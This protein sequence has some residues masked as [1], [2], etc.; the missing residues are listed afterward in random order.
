MKR[1]GGWLVWLSFVV[2]FATLLWSFRSWT[3]NE[4]LLSLPSHDHQEISVESH[5]V[6]KKSEQT[7]YS[8]ELAA[9]AHRAEPDRKAAL[10]K[11][12]ALRR[13]SEG[14]PSLA[15]QGDSHRV[16]AA[17]LEVE[18]LARKRTPI[19]NGVAGLGKLARSHGIESSKK[20]LA[21]IMSFRHYKQNNNEINNIANG[22]ESHS[23][24]SHRFKSSIDK[25]VD[26]KRARK[27]SIKKAK[28]AAA[29]R[30]EAGRLSKNEM[31][32][33]ISRQVEHSISKALEQTFIPIQGILRKDETKLDV[34]TKPGIHAAAIN[35]AADDA[36]GHLRQSLMRKL[37]SEVG[38][39]LL[40]RE[41]ALEHRSSAYLDKVH[42]KT[43]AT[44]T[45]I[46]DPDRIR[47]H[48]HVVVPSSAHETV[49]VVAT[50]KDWDRKVDALLRSS[51]KIIRTQ[52]AQYV[53][54]P[55]AFD[56]AIQA[57]QGELERQLK[58]VKLSSAHMSGASSSVASKTRSP[59]K[60]AANSGIHKAVPS[61]RPMSPQ[62]K[63]AFKKALDSY[64]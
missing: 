36:A 33:T 11:L 34:L 37:H 59:V 35:H 58:S 48:S 18:N 28:A 38:H 64:L 14:G 30:L 17:V 51:R 60:L 24:I 42:K 46:V 27:E 31:K 50:G 12:D 16:P 29:L 15:K 3:N 40:S 55:L 20:M 32:K 22:F 4:V 21:E 45:G 2:C 19:S 62:Q 53:N 6:Q 63:S 5:P 49:A 41:T 43:L 61:A 54:K 57:T 44:L 23:S 47:L 13:K 9:L 39:V 7:K 26:A 8:E 56:T 10:A 1:Q 52:Q 25:D